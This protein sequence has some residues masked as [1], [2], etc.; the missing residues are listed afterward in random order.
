M[1]CASAIGGIRMQADVKNLNTIAETIKNLVQIKSET[2]AQC[3]EG[4]HT[5]SQVLNDAQNELS[6]SNN[7]LNVCK[8]VE[9]AKL[10]K[11]LEVEA[12]MAQAAAAEASAIASGNPVAIAAASAKVAAIAPE[13]A[14]AI[15][16]YN[17]AVEHRQRIEHRCELA[18][19][20]V[21]IAQEMCDTLNMR[22][23]YSKAKVEEVVLKGSGRL[24]LAYDDLSKYLS[25][26]SPEAKKDILVWDNWKPK[27]NEPVKPDD[28]RDRLNVSK[29]VTNGILEYLY[30]TDTNF[31]V[32]VDRHSANII[33]P[34]MESNT[35]VQIKK[36][37]VG[38]LCEELV[39]RTFLPMG[40]SIETQHR[41]NLSDGSYTKV[42][43]ILHGLKQPLILGK[44]EGM[45]ARE[46][47]TL[48]I[49]V[50]AGH[51]NYIYSQISHLEKQAQGHKMCDVSCT[52]CTRDIKNLSLDREANVREK[53][54]NA[55]SP[56][57]GML[58]YKDDLDRDCID[59]VRSKVKQDV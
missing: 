56:M 55:G 6:M 5:A 13:L 51:K 11:K 24:Q 1:K 32:T 59:F 33:I 15:Q 45:G 39:I 57:L 50:K 26:I 36:N 28:I 47:G 7:I 38:R 25:R 37:I 14:R 29:N 2:F 53:V 21:N 44:G 52:V 35:I 31:R 49:E 8:T 22:F 19:K 23:G 27:E 46:G 18:Q 34:G 58:P 48:G 4:Q 3:D 30:T 12:R 17:E 40:T 16:E 43:M 41:E 42:D 20:C 10:A 54:R 9:A